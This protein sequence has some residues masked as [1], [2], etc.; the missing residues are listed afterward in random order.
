MKYI[1][2]IF[3][4]CSYLF[5]P[6]LYA[7]TPSKSVLPVPLTL[8]YAL[9]LAGND[10]NPN[11]QIALSDKLQALSKQDLFESKYGFQV[12]VYGQLAAVKAS[13]LLPENYPDRDTDHELSLFVSKRLYDFGRK[14][15]QLEVSSNQ[16]KAANMQLISRKKNHYL[17]ILQSYFNVILADLEFSYQ[18]EAMAIAYIQFDRAKEKLKLKKLSELELLRIETD[19]RNVS[20]ERSKSENAQRISRSILAINLDNPEQLPSDVDVPDLASIPSF[21]INRELI[22]IKQLQVMVVENNLDLKEINFQITAEKQQQQAFYADKYPIISGRIETAW[23]SRELGGSDKGVA[24]L[25]IKIPVYQGGEVNANAALSH[26]K[27]FKLEASHRQ[28]SMQ[29]RQQVLQ[30][31]MNLQNLKQQHQQVKTELNYR[32]L[33]LDKSRAEYESELKSDLGS[34]MVFLSAA[35]LEEKRIL[36]KMAYQWAELDILLGTKQLY[37]YAYSL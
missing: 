26:A 21:S 11:V 17:Q 33:Y 19:Y 16:I 14:D 32:E 35:Q 9:S 23:Y 25:S 31:W 12:G 18:N 1:I 13:S 29:L 2:K 27:L 6:N 15:K 30:I 3:I 22:E 7:E 8:E 10:N 4:L 20:V 34:A 37:G 36:Y 24:A 28:L 5:V